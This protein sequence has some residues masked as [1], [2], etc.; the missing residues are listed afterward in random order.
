[1]QHWIHFITAS[2][3]TP[4][5]IITEAWY[6]ATDSSTITEISGEV[7]QW[8]DK[9][10][11][12]QHLGQAVI[13]TQPTTNVRTLNGL[14]V[15]DFDGTDYFVSSTFNIPSS[16]D[17]NIFMVAVIDAIDN[18]FD[19]IFAMKVVTGNDFQFDANNVTQFNG[20]ITRSSGNNVNSVNGPYHG[21]TV[22]STRFNQT[23]ETVSAWYDGT[24]D[25]EEALSLGGQLTSPQDRFYVMTN[26]A[27]SQFTDGAVAEIVIIE[28]MTTEIQQKVEGYLAWKWGTQASLPSGHPYELGAPTL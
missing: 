5:N 8:D 21:P 6:D 14:N 19:S 13:G 28:D 16:G 1:M 26:R 27:D 11:N 23:G 9:S 10:G 4:E 12:G 25:G 20:D 24:K 3:W 18:A 7:S 22:Y 2:L 15:L 17:I